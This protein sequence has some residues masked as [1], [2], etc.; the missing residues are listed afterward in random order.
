MFI[1]VYGGGVV[2]VQ[3]A[4]PNVKTNTLGQS[5]PMRVHYMGKWIVVVSQDTGLFSPQGSLGLEV[6]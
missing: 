5:F 6:Q 3:G 2:L 1:S 4:Y